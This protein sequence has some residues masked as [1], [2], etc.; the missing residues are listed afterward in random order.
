MHTEN[1]LPRLATVTKAAAAFPDLGLTPAAIRCQIFKAYSRKNSR[2]DVIPG[3]GLAES[4]ALIRKG[5]KVMI[6]LDRYGDWLAGKAGAQ[7]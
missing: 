1:T 7:K 4:G 2:G 5:R 3:N 6:D